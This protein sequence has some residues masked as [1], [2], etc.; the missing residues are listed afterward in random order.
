MSEIITR[1]KSETSPCDSPCSLRAI[2]T[3]TCRQYREWTAT[4]MIDLSLSRMPSQIS[5]AIGKMPPSP[6]KNKSPEKELIVKQLRVKQ[7]LS[8]LSPKSL[9]LLS[10][11][12]GYSVNTL[13]QYRAVH[14]GLSEAFINEMHS[15]KVQDFLRVHRQPE[16]KAA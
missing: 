15:F 4:K 11:L 5:K 12:V 8:E 7:W 14:S 13:K 3:D 10:E 2:C 6:K 9:R 1:V 16:E